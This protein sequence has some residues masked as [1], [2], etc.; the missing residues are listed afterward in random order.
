MDEYLKS[1][2]KKDNNRKIYYLFSFLM[3]W[4]GVAWYIFP[5]IVRN[6]DAIG[7]QNGIIFTKTFSISM[8][9]FFVILGALLFAIGMSK[10][11]KG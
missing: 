8:L 10:Y 9:I 5:K 2:Y 4:Y 6:I 3:V 1:G 7:D 11:E